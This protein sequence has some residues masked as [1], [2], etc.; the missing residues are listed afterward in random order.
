MHT[1]NKSESRRSTAPLFCQTS[2][3]PALVCPTSRSAKLA[4]VCWPRRRR[5]TASM[6]HLL[7]R[8]STR[9]VLSTDLRVHSRTSGWP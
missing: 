5:S 8:Q 1:A 9:M 4:W 2:W 6:R 3:C 7:T